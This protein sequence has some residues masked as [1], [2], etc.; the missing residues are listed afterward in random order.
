MLNKLSIVCSSQNSFDDLKQHTLRSSGLNYKNIEFLGYTNKNQ[1]SLS[2]IYNKG[3]QDA[4]NQYVVFMHHDI[5]FMTDNWGS[6]LI[7]NFTRNPEFG[8]IGVAGTNHLVSGMWW[9]DR[10]AMHGIV[11]HTDNGKSWASKYSEDQ[12]NRIKPMVILDG[13]FF[14]VDKTK[15]VN[16]F[17]EDFKGFHFYDLGF[18]LSN[19]L[20]G[21]GIG[22]CTN[23]RITHLSVGMVNKE[24]EANKAQFE[25][26]YKP[27]LPCSL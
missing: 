6:K 19:Y 16:P 8:I 20:A 23:I 24:W 14:A 11:N 4:T 12:G 7:K 21:V 27:Y 18:M 26:K 5:I 17:D 13:V 22:V 3:L 1:Y 15:I 9:E 25:T 2:E 10:A